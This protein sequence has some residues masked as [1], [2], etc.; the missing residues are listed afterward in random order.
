MSFQQNLRKEFETQ[1]PRCNHKRLPLC[2]FCV[3]LRGIVTHHDCVK[4]F[5]PTR[6]PVGF[7]IDWIDML[8]KNGSE[9][10]SGCKK[11]VYNESQIRC[12]LTN[13]QEVCNGATI[14]NPSL[15]VFVK[16]F[17]NQ[18]LGYGFVPTCIAFAFRGKQKS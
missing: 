14:Q 11:I 3:N 10:S 8:H 17:A 1:T 16:R 9:L 5:C 12:K 13:L 15:D 7:V 2:G 18:P 4:S 6:V